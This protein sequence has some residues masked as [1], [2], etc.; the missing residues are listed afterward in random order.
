MR[1]ARI[2]L[3]FAI[4]VALL[5]VTASVY[6]LPLLQIPPV[7]HLVEGYEDCLVCH[8]ADEMVPFPEDHAGRG[9]DTCV[10][11]HE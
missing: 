1:I 9:N 7:P 8:A 10:A 2:V 4:L 6:G 11:C 3:A 5:L